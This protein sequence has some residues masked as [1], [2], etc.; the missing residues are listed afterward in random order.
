ML[1]QQV[2][3]LASIRFLAAT[4]SVCVALRALLACVQAAH[5]Q[6]RLQSAVSLNLQIR[7][8]ATA[9]TRRATLQSASP[10]RQVWPAGDWGQCQV[11]APSR[12]RIIVC[13]IFCCVQAALAA[14]VASGTEVSP[15]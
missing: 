13:I 3:R 12:H 7:P 4:H 15:Q 14:G 9:P 10:W 11:D 2:G 8:T 1:A 5:S 6:L